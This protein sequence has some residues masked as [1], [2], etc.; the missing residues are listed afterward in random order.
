MPPLGKHETQ[1]RSR[2]RWTADLPAMGT[3][4][5]WGAPRARWRATSTSELLV[6]TRKAH[7]HPAL[8][9]R[10]I[11]GNDGVRQSRRVDDDSVRFA[12]VVVATQGSSRPPYAVS[13]TGPTV[14]ESVQPGSRV[15]VVFLPCD[16]DRYHFTLTRG[17]GHRGQWTACC[18]LFHRSPIPTRPRWMLPGKCPPPKAGQK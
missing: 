16:F 15:P 8:E 2:E 5:H 1:R 10:H 17:C 3:K 14:A 9:S 7:G 13:C 18:V 11:S 6:L 12:G 4:V